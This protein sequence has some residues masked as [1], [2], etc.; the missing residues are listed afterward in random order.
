[1]KRAIV[2]IGLI[3]AAFAAVYGQTPLEIIVQGNTL[4][5]KFEWLLSNAETGKTYVI[6]LDRDET[7]PHGQDL[8]YDG[9]EITIILRGRGAMRSIFYNASSEYVPLFS[10]RIGVT[11]VIDEL[12]TLSL[13]RDEYDQFCGC[14][15]RI[16]SGGIFVMNNNTV[17]TCD[18]PFFGK[19]EVNGGTFVMNGG[20]LSG[21]IA[22]WALAGA[23]GE[24]VNVINGGVF[25]MNGGTISGNTGYNGGGVI[26]SNGSTFTMNGGTISGNIAC[27][28]G[29]IGVS[30]T[31]IMSNGIISSN[32]S[33][34]GGGVSIDKGGMFTMTGGIISSNTAKN[35]SQVGNIQYYGGG[36][37]LN[38]G[39]IFNLNSPA[40]KA[41]VTGNIAHISSQVYVEWGGIFRVNGLQERS[42]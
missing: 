17:I 4:T 2:L 12:I 38:E 34:G 32:T 21:I 19:V 29:G 30:G 28:G 20:T 33:R 8:F 40:T 36:V 10:I 42:Y 14:M 13:K 9:R 26:V 3:L 39:A 23:C 5:R 24:G 16:G 15:I 6:V 41:S 25:T 1:M 31:C 37:S 7:L 27:V 11:L 22:E 35:L 18:S